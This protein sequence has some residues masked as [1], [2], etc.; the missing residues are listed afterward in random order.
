MALTIYTTV[1]WDAMPCSKASHYLHYVGTVNH[2]QL[3]SVNI[4]FRNAGNNLPD[5]P[6]LTSQKT[7]LFIFTALR[8][9]NLKQRF[10]Y[11]GSPI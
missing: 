8:T 4:I 9:S 7:V 6:V 11:N 10:I 5:Y 2:D 3:A 1:F